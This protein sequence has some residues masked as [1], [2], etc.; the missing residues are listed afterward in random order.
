M[1]PSDIKGLRYFGSWASGSGHAECVAAALD[2]GMDAN[3]CDPDGKSPLYIASSVGDPD[4]V[5]LL[6]DCGADVD[7]EDFEG[8]TPSYV[9]SERGHVQVG[10]PDHSPKYFSMLQCEQDIPSADLTAFFQT[11][12]PGRI[13][14]RSSKHISIFRQHS[15]KHNPFGR[16]PKP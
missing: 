16:L 14:T 11:L 13:K 6:L 1:T 3:L 9:A 8:R 4:S 12:K 10:G 15:G 5:A 2:A 7:R